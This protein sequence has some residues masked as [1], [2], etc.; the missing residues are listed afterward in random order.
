MNKAG[1]VISLVGGVLAVVFSVML[2]FT[3]PLLYAG[4]DVYRFIKENAATEEEGSGLGK[5]WADIGDYYGIA[6]F[7]ESDFYD[8]VSDYV[9]VIQDIDAREFENLGNEYGRE[10][11]YDLARMYNDFEEYLP[12]LYLGTVACIIVSVIALIGAQIARRYRV[13]GGSVI[14]TCAALT[15]IFSLVASSIIPM[16]LA[17]LLLILGG[18]FQLASPRAPMAIQGP[19]TGGG[20][21]Q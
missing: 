20:E 3:G 9:D 13:V 7:L 21:L 14:L 16:A 18:I 15:L 1:Y 8:Y 6:P 10:T 5:M 4:D 2:V 17:S 19:E 11:F 12:K